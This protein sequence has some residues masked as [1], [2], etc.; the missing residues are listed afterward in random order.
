MEILING[1]NLDV[2]K[3]LSIAIEESNPIYN[4]RGTQSLPITVPLTKRNNRILQFPARID[5]GA[6][7][8]A[9][10]RTARVIDGAY[11]RSGVVNITEAGPEGI[12]FNVGFD[13]STAY[14]KWSAKK[15][16]ELSNLPVYSPIVSGQDRKIDILLNELYTVFQHPNSQ[17]D[18]FAVFPLAINKED[19]D[20]DNMTTTYWEILNVP[21]DS[22]LVQPREVK[23]LIDGE[24]TSVSIPEGYMVS[25]FLR[26]WRILELIFTDL[27]VKIS[28]NPFKEDLELSRLVVL[29]NAADSCCR[30]EIRYADLMP[31]CTVSEFLN[32]L[33]VRFG[34]VY[35]LNAERNTA[36]LVLI[37]DIIHSNEYYTIDNYKY[38]IEKIIYNERQYI[39]LS[40]KTSIEGSAPTH[41]RF[42]DFAKGIDI[43]KVKRGSAVPD[44]REDPDLIVDNAACFLFLQFETGQW[45]KLDYSNR[46]TQSQSSSFFNWDPQ[47]EGYTALELTSEDEFVPVSRVRNVNTGTGHS[48]NNLCPTYLFGTRH[49]HSYIKGSDASETNK[50]TTPLAFMFAYT[51]GGQ[52]IGRITPE[53]PDGR[54]ITLDDGTS[55]SVSLFFQFKDGLFNT[56]WADYDELLRHG[57]RTIEIATILKKH[58]LLTLDIL[59]P[60]RLGNIRC[61]IDKASYSLPSGQNVPVDLTLRTIQPHGSYDIKAE[62]NVPDFS[63]ANKHLAWVF[64]SDTYGEHLDTPEVRKDAAQLFID[65]TEYQPHGTQG[66][67]YYVGASGLFFKSIKRGD[68]TWEDDSF[69]MAIMEGE[70]RTGWYPAFITYTV[71]EIHDMTQNQGDEED[72][73]LSEVPLGDVTIE[74]GYQVT[75]IAKWVSD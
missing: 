68:F 20:A 18:D 54:P 62:Q 53:G 70:I 38:G 72:I 36:R 21:G 50:D 16:A 22:G 44:W 26:V 31:D 74:V 35:N 52:T 17:E 65:G 12:S 59:H 10:Q 45:H 8:N 23:R 46:Q 3:E 25:P 37:R 58:D 75:V 5:T 7:P 49:F 6:D 34:L 29:N 64:R 33:W 1:E 30:G 27:G 40:A 48:F 55:P 11:M 28:C 2:A 39:K 61:L 14:A 66:D 41:E 73:E 13:N 60:V 51:T 67:Y 24:I 47:P 42:E 69:G 4:D 71:Y 19:L 43:S 9:P 56:Y 15:L 63:V 32:S 57:N